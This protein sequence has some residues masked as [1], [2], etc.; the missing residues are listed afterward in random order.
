MPNTQYTDLN[1]QTSVAIWLANSFTSANWKVYWQMTQVMSGTGSIG[2]VT[3]V[4]DFPNEPSII[5][6]PPRVRNTTE[7]LLPALAISIFREPFMEARAGL[8]EDL[9]RQSMT[10]RIDGYTVDQVQHMVFATMFRNWFRDGYL[11]GVYDFESNPTNPPFVGY[12]EIDRLAVD[13]VE[14]TEASESVRYY[15][16][17]FVDFIY[18][19]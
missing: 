17:A 7:I 3:I 11:V 2:E 13:K 8:G 6:L 12:L 10:A 9:F 18:F 4:P 19:D 5:V 1:L 16:S 14:F 15:V